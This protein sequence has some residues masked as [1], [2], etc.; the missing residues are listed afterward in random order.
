MAR[1]AYSI[2]ALCCTDETATREAAICNQG[3]PRRIRFAV[4]YGTRMMPMPQ[5]PPVF[6]MGRNTAGLGCAPRLEGNG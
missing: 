1:K 5:L 4:A 6:V 3:F 2:S